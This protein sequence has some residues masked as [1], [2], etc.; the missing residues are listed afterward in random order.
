MSN[1]GSLS[2]ADVE[3]LL[4]DRSAAARAETVEKIAGSMT[5][6]GFSETERREAEEIFRILV[7]DAEVLVRKTLAETLKSVP[8][9]PHDIAKTLA[10]DIADVATPML[11]FSSALTDEDLFDIISSKSD[12][13][14]MAVASRE[15]VSE[16]VSEKLADSGSEDVVATLMQNGGAEISDATYEKVLDQFGESEKIQAPMAHRSKLPITVTERLVTMVSDKLREHLVTHHEMS[17]G[18]ATDLILESREKTMIGFIKDGASHSDLVDLIDQLHENNR[19]TPTIILRA[20]CV[21]DVDFFETAMAKYSNIAVSN[22]HILVTDAGG[23]GLKQLCEKSNIPGGLQQ[24]MRVGLDVANE[25]DFDGTP[26]DRERYRNQVIERVLT[27]FQ[28]EFDGENVDYLIAKLGNSSAA[29][30]QAA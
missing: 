26:G 25:L 8:D 30:S 4:N 23:N 17:P 21:G 16:A 5:D 7:S 24:I 19:L 15:V 11:S 18:M 9:L 10:S 6:T 20:L 12:L 14:Q 22:V 13:H 1:N 2:P 28:D 29:D 27:H 3:R